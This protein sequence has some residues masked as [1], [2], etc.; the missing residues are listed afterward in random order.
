MP[1]IEVLRKGVTPA[2]RP[3]PT[4]TT[5]TV[6]PMTLG[7]VGKELTEEDVDKEPT[8]I[9]SVDEAFKQFQPSHRFETYAGE[10]STEFVADLDFRSLKDFSPENIQ[11]KAPGKRN[12]IAD[13]KTTIDLLY[14][15]KDRWALPGVK[16]AWNDPS[17]RQQIL[18]ALTKLRAELEKVAQP[19]GGE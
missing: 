14:R 10:E 4:D 9:D 3:V 15:L 5:L 18:G 8:R 13:L 17:Q 16:R 19:Q 11:K 12:D 6:L 2:A 1:K 7:K